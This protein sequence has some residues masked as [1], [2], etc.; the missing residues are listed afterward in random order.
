[1]PCPSPMDTHSQVD[2]T[3]TPPHR[4]PGLA[5]N[6]FLEKF[7]SFEDGFKHVV[8]WRNRLF[9]G[10]GEFLPI[11]R[12]AALSQ[13]NAMIITMHF[14]CI[15]WMALVPVTSQNQWELCWATNG[16]TT[17]DMGHVQ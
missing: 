5:L 4:G 3:I 15:G 10:A 12:H 6:W 1:M 17:Y 14:K 11:V 9:A 16:S 7:R 8:Q 2:G 13:Q